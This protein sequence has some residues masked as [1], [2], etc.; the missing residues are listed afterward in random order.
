MITKRLKQNRLGFSLY[1]LFFVL[2]V[3]FSFRG[4]CDTAAEIFVIRGT[5]PPSEKTGKETEVTICPGEPV[6]IA[7]G[8]T[9]DVT[10]ASISGIGSVSPKGSITVFPSQT[11]EYAISVN[12]DCT[13][14]A[15]CKINVVRDGDI[16]AIG[17]QLVS[18]PPDPK[19]NRPQQYYWERKLD[20]AFW[21]PN[22]I[23]TG[24]RMVRFT[25]HAFNQP[26]L[27]RLIKTDKDGHVHDNI[28]AGWE[29]STS[30]G[31]D[32][33]YLVGDWKVFMTGGVYPNNPPAYA[34]FEVTMRCRH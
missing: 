15:K 30:W 28:L 26:V 32:T 23:V 18:I 8:S 13:R 16:A 21:S 7:W 11:T 10:S 22:I 3:C 2:I 9:S 31:T 14:E 17:A 29:F 4:C 20:E 33:I 12:G 25:E 27:W 6:T 5:M 19:L 34:T 1:L 24:V